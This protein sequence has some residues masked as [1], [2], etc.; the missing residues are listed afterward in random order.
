MYCFFS[1]WVQQWKTT[2]CKK[3]SYEF[4]LTVH[5]LRR[6]VS[7]QC[8]HQSSGPAWASEDYHMVL[9]S[10]SFVR[11]LGNLLSTYV[12]LFVKL[13]IL[14]GCRCSRRLS[15]TVMP[16][17]LAKWNSYVFVYMFQK[18]RCF[19]TEPKIQ[20]YRRQFYKECISEYICSHIYIFSYLNIYICISSSS[21]LK[22]SYDIEYQSFRY[23]LHVFVCTIIEKLY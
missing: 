9:L 23:I 14:K 8:I 13:Y 6:R 2:C 18:L 22:I 10:K 19:I 12:S 1:E 21:S 16:S 11:V 5:K 20:A 7:L 3:S 17:E 15:I 4:L